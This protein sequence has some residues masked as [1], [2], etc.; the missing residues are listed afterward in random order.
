MKIWHI[1]G[2]YYEI[3]EGHVRGHDQDDE[4]TLKKKKK[5]RLV[6]TI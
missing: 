2:R 4:M 6:N 5:P 3:P 1:I